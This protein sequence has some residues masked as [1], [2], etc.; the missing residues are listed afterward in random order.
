MYAIKWK[1][2]NWLIDLLYEKRSHKKRNKYIIVKGNYIKS[3]K[4]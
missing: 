4:H 3:L 2:T 1:D